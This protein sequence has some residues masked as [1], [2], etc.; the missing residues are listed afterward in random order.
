MLWLD[1][2]KLGISR[3][4]REKYIEFLKMSEISL[5]YTYKFCEFEPRS[6]FKTF[7][8][9]PHGP[10]KTNPARRWR[11]GSDI[12]LKDAHSYLSYVSIARAFFN[13]LGS[14]SSPT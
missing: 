8:G 1:W 13:L 10:N 3:I 5:R 14:L 6:H 11:T 12:P 2:N 4:W 7:R 9:H